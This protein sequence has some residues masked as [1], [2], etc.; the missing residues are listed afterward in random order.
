MVNRSNKGSERE[1]EAI[2]QDLA[3]GWRFMEGSRAVRTRYQSNDLFNVWDYA[4]WQGVNL[5]L[6]K[7]C[8]YCRGAGCGHCLPIELIG[9]QLPTY[10]RK[11][12]QVCSGDKGES[13]ESDYGRHKTKCLAWLATHR[14]PGELYELA[15]YRDARWTGRGKNRAYVKK[16]WRRELL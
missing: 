9:R 11:F 12:V 10:T 14:L 7:C 8:T 16:S 15:V 6:V 3:A 5:E 1:R 13:P 4:V 2:K